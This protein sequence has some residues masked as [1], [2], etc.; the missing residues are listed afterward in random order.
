MKSRNYFLLADEYQKYWF[1]N[2]K[3]GEIMKMIL[4]NSKIKTSFRIIDMP[5]EEMIITKMISVVR[6]VNDSF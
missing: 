5:G 3:I 6:T 4:K 1:Y 2:N